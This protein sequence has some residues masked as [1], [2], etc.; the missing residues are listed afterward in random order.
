MAAQ[1]VAQLGDAPLRDVPLVAL[2]GVEQAGMMGRAWD[3]MRL[4]IK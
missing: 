1:L 4:W 3:A 2:D